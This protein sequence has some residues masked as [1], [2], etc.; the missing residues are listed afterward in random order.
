MADDDPL[1][2]L[3]QGYV[4]QDGVSGIDAFVPQQP[5]A[6][7]WFKAPAEPPEMWRPLW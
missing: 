1:D 2:G 7:R 4:Q 6:T 5:S 3:D